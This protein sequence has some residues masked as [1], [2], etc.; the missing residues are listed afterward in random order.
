MSKKIMLLMPISSWDSSRSTGGVDSVCQLLIKGIMSDKVNQYLIIGFNPLN[1]IKSGKKEIDLASNIHLNWYNLS[2]NKGSFIQ[3]LIPNLFFQNWIIKREALAF[4]PDIIHAHL[5]SWFLYK[6]YNLKSILTLHTYKNICRRNFGIINHILYVMIAAPISLKNSNIIT[7]VSRDIECLLQ[8][9]NLPVIYIPNPILDIFFSVTRNINDEI[10]VVMPSNVIPRKRIHDALEII[11]KIRESIPRIKLYIAGSFSNDKYFNS[12]NEY[13]EQHKLQDNIAFLGQ[14][15]LIDLC[16]LYSRAHAGLFLSEEETFGLAPLEMIA[17]GLPIVSTKVGIFKHE[18][19][20]NSFKIRFVNS[21]EIQN[22]TASL[23]DILMN[24]S[25]G[26]ISAKDFIR[27]RY[28][29][30]NISKQYMRIYDS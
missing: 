23:L 29:V 15:S 8:K 14:I 18:E 12:L 25:E 13:I 10:I 27:T 9:D 30:D 21:G 20:F 4:K 1:D 22:A 19:I 17:S 11:N 3:K 7:T 16:E 28:S 2:Q 6:Y 26:S 5:P 24:R